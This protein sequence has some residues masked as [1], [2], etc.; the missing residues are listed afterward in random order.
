MVRAAVADPEFDRLVAFGT[1]P[2][3]GCSVLVDVN[4]NVN[5]AAIEFDAD[6]TTLL[7]GRG[8]GRLRWNWCPIRGRFAGKI[9]Q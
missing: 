4:P 8:F 7:G 3:V 1:A 2:L 6:E 5:A 9:D